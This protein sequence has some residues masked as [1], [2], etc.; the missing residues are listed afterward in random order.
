[1]LAAV[2]LTAISCGGSSSMVRERTLSGFAEIMKADR[3]YGMSGDQADRAGLVKCQREFRKFYSQLKPEQYGDFLSGFNEFADYEF[4][5]TF[6]A[7]LRRGDAAEGAYLSNFLYDVAEAE[8][9]PKLA[10]FS[11][12]LRDVCYYYD[13]YPAEERKAAREIIDAWK[14]NKKAEAEKR[15]TPEYI[16]ADIMEAFYKAAAADNFEDYSEVD[17]GAGEM[18]GFTEEEWKRYTK[19]EQQWKKDNAKKWKVIKEYR[20][21]KIDEGFALCIIDMD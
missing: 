8:H 16:A 11:N 13:H 17:Y 6:Y 10:A 7:T 2:M 15:S 1:M 20:K 3:T 18:D 21:K 9:D 19:A 14:A 4:L 5:Q 12:E